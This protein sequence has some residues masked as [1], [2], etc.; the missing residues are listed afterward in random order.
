MVCVDPNCQDKIFETFCNLCE[1][2]NDGYHN[3][4]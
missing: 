1:F 2:D 4:E 3:N